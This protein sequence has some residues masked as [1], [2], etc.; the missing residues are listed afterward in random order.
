MSDPQSDG[1]RELFR[2]F[3]QKHGWRVEFWPAV[4]GRSLAPSDFPDWVAAG[5]ERASTLQPLAPSE[6]GLLCST[7]SLLLEA[8]EKNL[9][10]L[11]VFEDDAIVFAPP[12]LRVPPRFDLVFFN[13]GISATVDG[14][15]TGGCGGLGYLLS[16]SGIEKVLRMLEWA[17]EPIDLL[18]LKA[19]PT[20]EF[21]SHVRQSKRA[22]I[23]EELI[24]EAYFS[25]PL[26]FHGDVF[27]STLR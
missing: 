13:S 10:Y 21:A 12:H 18:F 5:G 1:R 22:D 4:D 16:R 8:S 17:D 7:R 26:V 15:V 25:G 27:R 24:L 23:V 3:V 9:D 6:V 20:S 2:H 14:R 19:I 11:A